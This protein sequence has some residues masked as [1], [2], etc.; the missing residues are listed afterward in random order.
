MMLSGEG[1]GS[2]GKDQTTYLA[3]AAICNRVLHSI[4]IPLPHKAM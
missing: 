3:G 1:R 4:V 2:G